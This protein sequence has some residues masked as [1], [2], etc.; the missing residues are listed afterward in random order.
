MKAADFLLSF[1]RSF[2][3]VNRTLEVLLILFFEKLD[4]A[5]E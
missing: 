5:N 4:N 1:E 3:Q 2:S